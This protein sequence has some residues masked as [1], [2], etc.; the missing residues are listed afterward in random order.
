MRHVALVAL[1]RDDVHG[2]GE[3]AEAVPQRRRRARTE[4]AQRGGERARVVAQQVLAP[5]PR[6]VGWRAGEQRQS[7]PA[8]GER[9]DRVAG[10]LV[11]EALVGGAPLRARRV[12]LDPRGR[13][14]EHEALDPAGVRER[15]VQG[16]APA[17]RVAAQREARR[18]GGL[19][20]GHALGDAD[21]AAVARV[22]VAAEVQRERA[23]PF[24]PEPV[25]DG[26]P[27]VAGAREAV[28]QNDRLRHPPRS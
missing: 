11:R 28:Q 22:A 16:D 13:G 15:E 1:A 17:H 10:D 21:G 3:L 20:V 25:G 6:G 5:A 9:L 26:P 18:R 14:E 23:I 8:L 12:V 24:A 4:P 27:A 2:H 7:H 19:D